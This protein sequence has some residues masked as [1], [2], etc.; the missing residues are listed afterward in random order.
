MEALGR[1]AG[2]CSEGNGGREGSGGVSAA[3]LQLTELQRQRISI[4]G[5]ERRWQ[6]SAKERTVQRKVCLTSAAV[7]SQNGGAQAVK[8]T[9]RT[10]KDSAKG[11][12]KRAAPHMGRQWKGQ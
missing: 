5:G 1:P 11:Q 9:G 8:R 2:T 3:E 4:G 6:D 7:A 12:R 10:V